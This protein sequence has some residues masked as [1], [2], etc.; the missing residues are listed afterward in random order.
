M[1]PT[2]SM[3][4]LRCAVTL[5]SG[6]F[7]FVGSSTHSVGFPHGAVVKNPSISARDAGL[8]PGAGRSPGVGND[9]FFS[10]LFFFFLSVFLPGKFYGQRSLVGY[11]PWGHR[12]LDT[13]ELLNTRTPKAQHYALYISLGTEQILINVLAG[14]SHLLIETH[15]CLWAIHALWPWEK[16]GGE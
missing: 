7:L 4:Y 13:T 12:E 15:V 10:I 3:R 2:G 5:P 9:N 6:S 11:S 16:K 1:P 8:I 14:W